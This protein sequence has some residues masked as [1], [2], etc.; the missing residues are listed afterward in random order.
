MEADF[1]WSGQACS[2]FSELW[3]FSRGL[4]ML[5][6]APWGCRPSR[7]QAG[8]GRESRCSGQLPTNG[9]A[10]PPGWQVDSGPA[11]VHWVGEGG[12][13]G[14]HSFLIGGGQVNLL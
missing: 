4:A 11:H 12:C 13:T 3:T 9:E 6:A 2:R 5:A 1:A 8:Q 14:K 10:S 7:G